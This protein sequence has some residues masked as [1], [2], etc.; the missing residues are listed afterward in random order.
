MINKPC[1]IHEGFVYCPNRNNC[2][3]SKSCGHSEPHYIKRYNL[4]TSAVSCTTSDPHD[5][6]PGCV[7]L[8]TVDLKEIT[9]NCRICNQI[10]DYG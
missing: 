10:E 1:V 9:D 7:K 6:C 4:G 3:D 8:S 5:D 2:Q